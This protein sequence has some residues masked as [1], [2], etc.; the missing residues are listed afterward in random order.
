MAICDSSPM[1]H[2]VRN[3]KYTQERGHEKHKQ[4]E[5]EVEREEAKFKELAT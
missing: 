3:G 2:H 5:Y 1:G 4:S